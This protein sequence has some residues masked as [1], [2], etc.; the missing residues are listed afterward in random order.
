MYRMRLREW[1]SGGRRRRCACAALLAIA[2]APPAVIFAA[3]TH[4]QPA[5]P[6]T[7]AHYLLGVVEQ[8][9]R[10]ATRL[11]EA[12]ETESQSAGGLRHYRN[13]VSHRPEPHEC[14]PRLFGPDRQH[15]R[16]HRDG[17]LPAGAPAGRRPARRRSGASSQD[18]LLWSTRE[19]GYLRS[20]DGFVQVEQHHAAKA[21]S[22]RARARPGVGLEAWPSATRSRSRCTTPL[23]R[24]RRHRRRP[25]AAR[26]G[27]VSDRR[28]RRVTRGGDHGRRRIRR[29]GD[30]ARAAGMGDSDRG[31]RHAGARARAAVRAE[32]TTSSAGSCARARNRE[33]AAERRAPRLGVSRGRA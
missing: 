30:G 14:A 29:R 2:D 17:R 23:R 13:R 26:R 21:Q 7:V 9:E 33:P 19:V 27:S 11:A 5:Q 12:Y 8:L 18:M 16:Q 22:R 1:C 31:R 25:P 20:P 6:T 32:P 15:L 24:H 28:A 3:H 10:D 4:A